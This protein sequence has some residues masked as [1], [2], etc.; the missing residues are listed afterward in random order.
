MENVP[1]SFL[2]LGCACKG[3]DAWQ[4]WAARYGIPL[5][6]VRDDGGPCECQCHDQEDEYDEE[7]LP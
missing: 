4:C 1:R 2:P 5:S 6:E 7:V 3:L